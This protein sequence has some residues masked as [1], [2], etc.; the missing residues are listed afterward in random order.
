MNRNILYSC[1]TGNETR[2]CGIDG[3][4]GG[5]VWFFD[6]WA[7]ALFQTSIKVQTLPSDEPQN[8]FCAGSKKKT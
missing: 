2:F 7:A 4:E 8:Q 6:M 1:K 3:W 5:L